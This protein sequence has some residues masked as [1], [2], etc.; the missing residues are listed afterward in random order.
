MTV[1]YHADVIGSL[2]RPRYLSEARAALAAGRISNEEFK[3]IEDR[4]V[5]A[6]IAMQEGCG[7]DFVNGGELRRFSFLDHLLGD[8]EGVADM[9][10]AA[11]HFHAPDPAQDWDWH[12]PFTVTGRIHGPGTFTAGS[13]RRAQRHRPGYRRQRW[14]TKE[15]LKAWPLGQRGLL[16]IRQRILKVASYG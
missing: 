15:V 4:A 9:P 13:G 6:A 5:E 2:L 1:P 8:M 11:V 14:S 10:G 7:L 12:S 16:A 3:R